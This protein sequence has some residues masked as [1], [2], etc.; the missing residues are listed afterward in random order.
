VAPRPI[1]DVRMIVRHSSGLQQ[2]IL[3]GESGGVGHLVYAIIGGAERRNEAGIGESYTPYRRYI[4][5]TSWLLDSCIIFYCSSAFERSALFRTTHLNGQFVISRTFLRCRALEYITFCH[6][7]FTPRSRAALTSASR[8][9]TVVFAFA[10]TDQGAT[11][12]HRGW[13]RLLLT[14]HCI[15]DCS[16]I[17]GNLK[18]PIRGVDARMRFNDFRHVERLRG[19]MTNTYELVVA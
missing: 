13:S 2:R 4:Q 17:D 14:V 16:D 11:T 19:T 9:M 1:S 10:T 7:R 15:L 6:F 12:G 8:S 5:T 18:F 3:C